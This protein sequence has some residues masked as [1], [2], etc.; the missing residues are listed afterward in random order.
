MVIE[1]RMIRNKQLCSTV[2]CIYILY[3]VMSLLEE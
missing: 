3:I 1:K 2:K